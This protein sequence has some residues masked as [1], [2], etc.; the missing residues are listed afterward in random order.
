MVC[1]RCWVL[2]VFLLRCSVCCALRG[3]VCRGSWNSFGIRQCWSPQGTH[4][5]TS[6][7]Q[8]ILILISIW[9]HCFRLFSLPF[10]LL[11]YLPCRKTLTSR[12]AETVFV[13]KE[14]MTRRNTES[15]H[16]GG[17]IFI[18]EKRL[19]SSKGQPVNRTRYVRACACSHWE[20][21]RHSPWGIY[22]MRSS[23]GNSSRTERGI[24]INCTFFD[25]LQLANCRPNERS[26]AVLDYV[27]R[28]FFTCS[29][30]R[31]D[32]V[33]TSHSLAYRRHTN[34]AVVTNKWSCLI[35]IL[36]WPAPN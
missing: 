9:S 31:T 28:F 17:Q 2:L 11:L 14:W 4:M 1:F 24:K 19:S 35:F 32:N 12:Q 36:A 18:I 3:I 34:V 6:I 21:L 26:F 20:C 25:M 33:T 13:A 27:R 8:E 22:L 5:V 30:H 16:S 10:W 23:A 7:P 15:S 29:P